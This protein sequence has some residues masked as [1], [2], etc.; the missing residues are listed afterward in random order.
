MVIPK[1]GPDGHADHRRSRTFSDEVALVTGMSAS[2]LNSV[3]GTG[4]GMHRGEVGRVEVAEPRA[5]HVRRA[6]HTRRVRHPGDPHRADEAAVVVQVGLDDVEAAVG[7]HP[8]EPVL[9]G[10][11]LAPGDRDSQ[12][13][14][15]RLRLLQVVEAARLLVEARNR[16]PPSAGRSRSPSGAS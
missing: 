2:P 4:L 14:G 3:N 9:A 8:A 15:D 10:L 5:R 11:L 1:P 6:E 16:I 7:D 13:V 12:R